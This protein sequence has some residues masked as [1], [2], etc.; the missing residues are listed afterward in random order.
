MRKARLFDGLRE[1]LSLAGQ[2]FQ[3]EKD[4]LCDGGE[5]PL[6][7]PPR[8]FARGGGRHHD[9]TKQEHRIWGLIPGLTSRLS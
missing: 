6:P 7:P 1:I 5:A 2:F 4:P 3:I 9:E 8:V